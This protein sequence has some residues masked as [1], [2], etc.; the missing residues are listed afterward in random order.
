MRRPNAKV[1]KSPSGRQVQGKRSKKGPHKTLS[2]YLEQL[3]LLLNPPRC[4]HAVE[5]GGDILECRSGRLSCFPCVCVFFLS[6]VTICHHEQVCFHLIACPILANSLQA[7]YKNVAPW[8]SSFLSPLLGLSLS[9]LPYSFQLRS[10]ACEWT[11]SMK[12]TPVS[13]RCIHTMQT[14][15][16]TP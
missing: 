12:P 7:I 14:H 10:Q 16:P 6:Q 9:F 4:F 2:D 8:S 1:A 3:Q 13:R 5:D 15:R 11:Q